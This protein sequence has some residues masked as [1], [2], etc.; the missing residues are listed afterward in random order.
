MSSAIKKFIRT[1]ALQL[2]TAV[3]YSYFRWYTRHAPPSG[4][5]LQ[6][7]KALNYSRASLRFMHVSAESNL[8]LECPINANDVILDVGGY[9]GEWAAQMR[10]HYDAFLH[11]FEPNP[12]AF[13]VL[14]RKFSNDENVA[15]HPFGLAAS[16]ATSRLSI[17]A[18]G[19][20]VY[21]DSPAE[22]GAGEHREVI[23]RD[24][25]QVF[26]ELGL[27]EVALLKVNIEGGEYDLLDRLLACGLHTRCK[28]IRVQFHEW[29]GSAHR[30]RKRIV[31][32]LARTHD[33]E[34]SYP[35]V[36]ESWRRKVSGS[37]GANRSTARGS[38]S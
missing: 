26:D 9:T 3:N 19:S 28:Y 30:L 23:L 7:F 31:R 10:S 38:H 13:D 29:F 27:A 14:C 2:R 17:A 34:W 11:I 37:V 15:L 18:M 24:V 16:N 4:P 36:W 5:A 25:K 35:F 20:S 6:I 8:L 33:P 32:E 22:R 1:G 21:S 12:E